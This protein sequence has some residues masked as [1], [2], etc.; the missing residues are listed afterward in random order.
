MNKLTKA[1][2]LFAALLLPVLI[3]V[4]LKMFGNNEFDIPVYNHTEISEEVNCD[5]VTTPHVVHILKTKSA[6]ITPNQVANIYHI[7]NPTTGS[8]LV[9]RGLMKVKDR[10]EGLEA[11]IHSISQSDISVSTT[12][13]TEQ[14][15]IGGIWKMYQTDSQSFN[16]FINCELMI[17]GQ[18]S[19][20]LVDQKGVI[21]GYYDGE[22]GE[23]TDRLILESKIL[24]YEV[25]NE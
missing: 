21:R 24:L 22:D 14:Y 5:D 11:V 15:Q 4:F 25:K 8:K 1:V 18:E 2:I 9:M 12:E 10:M 7:Y 3:F 19:L 13:L 23:E 16:D 17:T 6:V 20:V